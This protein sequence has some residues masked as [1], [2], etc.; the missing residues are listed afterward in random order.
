M[1]VLVQVENG[2]KLFWKLKN[3]VILGKNCIFRPL[4]WGVPHVPKILVMGQSNGSFKKT[5]KNAPL[6]N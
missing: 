4:Y 5:F 6:T 3:C 1:G 2:D